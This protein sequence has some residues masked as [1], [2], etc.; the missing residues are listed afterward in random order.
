MSFKNLKISMKLTVAFGGFV[1]LIILS[2]LFSLA[3]MN[4]ANDGMK[5]V[6]YESYPIASTAGQMMDNFYS[7]IGIQELILL[8][9]RGSDKRR[10]ELAKITL[11]IN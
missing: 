6:L 7:F 10:E 1:A 4:R 3:N 2:S 9:D 5:Q 11:K 8:D